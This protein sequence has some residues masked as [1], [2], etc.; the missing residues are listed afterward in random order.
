VP[1][2]GSLRTAPAASSSTTR[3]LSLEVTAFDG[4]RVLGQAVIDVQILDDSAEFR[5]PQ[6]DPQ[7][8]EELARLSGGKVLR[9]A[10]DLSAALKNIQT[11]PGE[12]SVARQ[13]AWDRPAVWLLLLMLMAVEWVIRRARGLA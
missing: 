8:L 3:T 7:R 12:L 2:L 10:E 13:P 11:S 5:N 4:G 6:P 1:P 9:N